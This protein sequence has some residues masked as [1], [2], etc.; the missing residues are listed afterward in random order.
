MIG[1]EANMSSCTEVSR[2]T[3]KF[4]RGI[5]EPI[6]WCSPQAI[7][8]ITYMSV[9]LKYTYVRTKLGREG[10]RSKTPHVLMGRC[11]SAHDNDDVYV[12]GIEVYMYV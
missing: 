11:A 5:S 9:Q 12:S 8:T 3:H 1:K 2:F 6:K 10:T 4:Q 7:I